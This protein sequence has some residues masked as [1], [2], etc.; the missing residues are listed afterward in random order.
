MVRIFVNTN[1]PELYEAIESS[2]DA[3]DLNY[4]VDNHGCY[5]VDEADVKDAIDTIKAC[6]GTCKIV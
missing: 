3:G 1:D 6:G 2:F 4:D 5:L